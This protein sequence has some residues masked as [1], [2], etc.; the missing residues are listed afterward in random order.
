MSRKIGETWGRPLGCGYKGNPIELRSTDSLFDFAQ[1]RLRAA[2]P[3]FEP[4]NFESLFH[5]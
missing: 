4:S 2:V 1:G 3:T 5:H